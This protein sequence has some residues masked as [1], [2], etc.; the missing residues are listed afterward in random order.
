MK[1]DLRHIPA[2]HHLQQHERFEGISERNNI[3]EQVLTKWLQEEIVDLRQLL[4]NDQWNGEVP[5]EEAFVSHLLASLERRA[6]L[7]SEM[8]LKAVI[9]GTGIILHTNLGRARL[10]N[11]AVQ[12]VHDAAKHYSN[13]EYDLNNGKRGSRHDIVESLICELTG[14]E[15]A[16]VVNNN[17]AAVFFILR[18]F[19]KGKETIVSRGELVEI[20]GSFRVMSIMEESGTL[21]AEVGTTNKTHYDDYDRA[22][23]EKTAV[24]MKVHR[25]NFHM[26]G[27]TDEV[28]GSELAGLARENN[29]LLYEDLGSGAFFD[30]AN[31][32]IGNEP[33]VAEILRAG[34]DLVSCSGDKLL[35]GP[36]AG[37]IAGRK[38]WIDRLKKHQLARVLRIDKLTLAALEST[39]KAYIGENAEEQIPS[40]RDIL[41][42]QEEVGQRVDRFLGFAAEVAPAFQCEAAEDESRIGGGTMPNVTLP[43]FGVLLSHQSFST[44]KLANSLRFC[45]PPIITRMKDE[46]VFLDFRT[47]ADEEMEALLTALRELEMAMSTD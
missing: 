2:V 19:A 38:E 1:T 12:A 8:K 4:L 27:F 41:A 20:G 10:G 36:Q 34:V 44:Q 47:I 28:S 26:S 30:F 22:V 21:L 32:G 5:S 23:N 9:N 46:R 33:L 15:A 11:A 3:P 17:A 43:T 31:S 14:A 29:L 25:S 7:F 39:L 16:L 24:L 13:L 37:I 35:G 45:N 18:T 6:R 42:S 40:L